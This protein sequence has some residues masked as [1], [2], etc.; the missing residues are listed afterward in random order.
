M[1]PGCAYTQLLRLLPSP[2]YPWPLGLHPALACLH[3]CCCQ[4]PVHHPNPRL[5]SPCLPSSCQTEP[6]KK[7]R[8]KSGSNKSCVL[9]YMSKICCQV[10]GTRQRKQQLIQHTISSMMTLSVWACC[11]FRGIVADCQ[12]PEIDMR[13]M[14]KQR[15]HKDKGTCLL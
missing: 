6:A 14:V 8:S 13:Y 2:C 3:T 11:A 1:V 4:P 12:I 15:C 7:Q 10:L 9:L 5:L